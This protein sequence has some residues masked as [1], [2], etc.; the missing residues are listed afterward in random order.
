MEDLF[1]ARQPILDSNHHVFGYELLFRTG[2]ENFCRSS[3]DSDMASS[4]VISNA[5]MQMGMK[6]VHG[7]QRMFLNFS[8]AM[9]L[10]EIA[11]VLPKNRIVIEILENV[12]PDN[13]IYRVCRKYKEHGYTIALDDFVLSDEWRPLL[14]LTDII[15][16]DFILTKPLDR[17]EVI[18]QTRRPGMIYLAEK[19]ETQDDLEEAKMLGYQLFQ[20]YFFSKP[21]I[22]QSKKIPENKFTYIQLMRTIHAKYFEF[23]DIEKVIKNDLALTVKLLKF[24]N[25][26][27][28]GFR[29]SVHS[30][31][32]ALTLLGM[33]ELKKWI[34]LVALS[35]MAYDKP[36]EL[37]SIAVSRGRF[38]E[39]IAL[40]TGKQR[41][42]DDYFLAGMLSLVDAFLDRP[43]EEIL[44]EL[45]LAKHIT[46]AILHRE[47]EMGK[48]WTLAE[49]F[50]RAQWDIV[51]Q[52][53]EDLKIGHLPVPHLYLSA[54]D[55]TEKSLAGH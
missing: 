2:F 53:I 52:N 35:A 9:L 42:A 15:K 37:M 50:E 20:G 22:I 14:E 40:A 26:A 27:A 25:S 5:F 28:F 43:K 51:T 55:W 36:S 41:E 13:D 23:K 10:N 29:Q 8:R 21:V 7:N 54:I 32:Q 39:E 6:T 38:C 34:S 16:I 11:L 31:M 4:S 44:N 47:G 33:N 46:A 49:S 3:T 1:M 24:I 45:H 18:R 12:K 19:I 48:L 30:I 17:A